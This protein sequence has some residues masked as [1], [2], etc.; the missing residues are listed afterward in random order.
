[1]TVRIKICGITN[2]EDALAATHLGA[3]ALGFIFAASPRKI[4]VERAREIIKALPPFVK[5]VGVFV[6]EDPE[7]VSSIAAMCGLDILQLHGSESVDYCSSFDRRVIKAVRLQSRDDLD[8]LSQYVSVVDTL[9]LDTYLP[10][11]LGGT[12]IT[13]DWKLAVEA[14]RYGRIILAG[15]LNPE[16]VAAAISMVKPY[17]VDASSGLER[18]PGVKDH[19]KMAQFMR[20]AIQAASI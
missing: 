7:R 20:E 14:R 17:A 8:N 6:D 1:M 3:D 11:R 13:F 18:S 5:T 4:S 16:N 10:N 9:L 12:G 2:K 19:E 15:G